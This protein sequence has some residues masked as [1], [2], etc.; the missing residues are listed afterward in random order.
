[1]VKIADF[2]MITFNHGFS[3]S[4]DRLEKLFSACKCVR[5]FFFWGVIS[6]FAPPSDRPLSLAERILKGTNFFKEHTDRSK[7]ILLW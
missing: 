4:T 7:V 6:H 1:M 3:P 2:I 5:F